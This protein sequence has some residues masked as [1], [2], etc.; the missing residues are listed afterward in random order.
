MV[1]ESNGDCVLTL[2]K[3]AGANHK[4]NV[5]PL[6]AQRNGHGVSEQYISWLRVTVTV[7]VLESNGY[8]DGVKE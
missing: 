2:T 3:Q 7:T 8:S 1:F 4:M 6:T 5:P